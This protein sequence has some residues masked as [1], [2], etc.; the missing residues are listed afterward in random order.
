MIYHI[1]IYIYIYI[2]IYIIYYTPACSHPHLL[3]A[4]ALVVLCMYSFIWLN[5]QTVFRNHA[6][7]YYS[8]AD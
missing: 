1:C 7:V 6:S 4:A 5:L 3:G 8:G 2:Y